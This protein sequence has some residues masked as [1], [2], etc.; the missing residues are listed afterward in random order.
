MLL[1]SAK[2]VF[3]FEEKIQIGRNKDM[4]TSRKSLLVFII[5][6]VCLI[7]IYGFTQ[8]FSVEVNVFATGMK[9][10]GLGGTG[11]I[12]DFPL[13]KSLMM[14]SKIDRSNSDMVM[15]EF[16]RRFDLKKITVGQSILYFIKKH[17][18]IVYTGIG[19]GY[20]LVD[21]QYDIGLMEVSGLES[22][23]NFKIENAV[24]CGFE[25]GFLSY[26]SSKIQFD[27]CVSYKFFRPELY[28]KN[29]SIYLY[30]NTIMWEKKSKESKRLDYFNF[31]F[32]LRYS[33]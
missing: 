13:G 24:E 20:N 29:Y 26:L 31:S 23:F 19:Y 2:N 25:A 22:R 11:L 28:K 6:S 16:E 17:D 1:F 14:R 9:L 27:F 21:C 18:F 3:L 32:G 15:I 12:V 5:L 33:F 10:T 4:F 8:D 30:Q 7:P